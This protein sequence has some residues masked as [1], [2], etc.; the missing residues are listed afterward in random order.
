[1]SLKA[2]ESYIII[3]FI[4]YNN[5]DKIHQLLNIEAQEWSWMNSELYL[6]KITQKYVEKKSMTVSDLSD[7]LWF[8]MLSTLNL[9]NKFIAKTTH[10]QKYNIKSISCFMII[11]YEI[12]F[13]KTEEY[14]YHTFCL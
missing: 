7:L 5:D 10:V 9:S 4:S 13:V 12:N 2:T 3:K 8:K 11:K 14:E 1:M 6:I